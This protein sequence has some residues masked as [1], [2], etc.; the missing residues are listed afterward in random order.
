MMDELRDYRFYT[1]DMVHPSLTAINYIWECFK[2]VWISDDANNIM[3]QVDVVQKGLRH[4]SFNPNTT[5]IAHIM[6]P[7]HISCFFPTNHE[8]KY[9]DILLLD[10]LQSY[11]TQLAYL[12]ME[13]MATVQQF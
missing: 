1:D 12:G 8:T 5:Q 6:I 13:Q 4:R 9:I 11:K 3:E 7:L 10:Y 2:T